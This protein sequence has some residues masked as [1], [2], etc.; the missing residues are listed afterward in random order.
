MRNPD[1]RVDA[2]RRLTQI[3]VALSAERNIDRLL[4]MII[5]EARELTA[6][7]GGTLYILSEDK[8]ALHFAIVQNDTLK[9]RMGGSSGSIT[10]PPVPMVNPDGTANLSNVSAYVAHT[11]KVVN[12]PDVYDVEGFNF[13]G[14][15]KFDGT[16]GYRSK[17]MLVIPLRDHNDE[18]IGVLQL[19]NAK[20]S[21]TGEVIAFSAENQ[22]MAESLSSQA[23]VA[24]SKNRLILDLEN[25]LE[26]FIVT[27]A[28]TIDEK[29]PYTGGHVH[30]VADLTMAIVDKVNKCDEGPLRSVHFSPDEVKEL[31]YAAWLHDVGKITTPEYVV[32]K[33]TKL[34]T[35]HDRIETVK[36]RF[37]VLLKCAQSA[38]PCNGTA[39]DG[40]FRE[41]LREDMAFVELINRGEKYVSDDDIRRLQEIARRT[42]CIEGA[43]FPLLTEEELMNLSIRQGTLNKREREI[44]NNHA[45]VTYKI[46]SKMPFP[47]RLKHVPLYAG[48][49][50][51]KLDGTGY[52][53]GLDEAH[54][55]MQARII[56]LADIFEA[57]TAKDRPY[58]KGKTVSEAL[59]IMS[60][61]VK[62][63][64][65]DADLFDLF[66]K[67]RIY[68]DYAKRELSP[69]Q[70]D[71]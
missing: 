23:A 36:T 29:S 43:E 19:L 50:H 7:D 55:P 24:L 40:D 47:K 49:H 64:H 54:I 17:S 67:E 33:A 13:E 68:E 11:G 66:V 45:L 10:W 12:I 53:E 1:D 16:T 70:L 4:E 37:Q 28:T 22:M 15:K 60:F 34:E 5:D 21:N 63:R 51:E 39:G 44:V 71:L 25:L 32:D 14:T 27:V 62:D 30:R 58:K 69:H 41:R 59:K 31:W 9:V 52:P 56:A 26:A 2:I 65:L 46:L 35:V 57:L 20:D 6:A 38:S 48:A 61:M 42:Y 8:D 18:I 3:G